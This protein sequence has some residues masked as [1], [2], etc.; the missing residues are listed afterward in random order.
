M[1]AVFPAMLQPGLST[2]YGMWSEAHCF[3]L[4]KQAVCINTG[5]IVGRLRRTQGVQI[6]VRILHL[7]LTQLR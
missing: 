7:I 4:N 5:A 1:S 6:T 2:A 3:R